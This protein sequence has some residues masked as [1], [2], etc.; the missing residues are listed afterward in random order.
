MRPSLIKS[1]DTY[2]ASTLITLHALSNQAGLVQYLKFIAGT[3]KGAR[4]IYISSQF[5]LHHN[6]T[7]IKKGVF[8][9]ARDIKI[10]FRGR[11]ADAA[12]RQVK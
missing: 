5:F 10:G 8:A 11:G 7:R 6:R 12:R 4:F 2:Q 3:Q 9:Q 1:R